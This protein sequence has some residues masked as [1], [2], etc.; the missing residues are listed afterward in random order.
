MEKVIVKDRNNQ[1]GFILNNLI[2]NATFTRTYQKNSQLQLDWTMFN[3]G[4]PAAELVTNENLVQFR[5]QNYTITLP[6]A[7]RLPSNTT[8]QVTAIHVGY[9]CD[10]FRVANSELPAGNYTPQQIM[11]HFF[12]GNDQGYSYKIVGSFDAVNIDSVGKGTGRTGLDLVAQAWPTCVLYPDNKQ[13]IIY[14]SDSWFHKVNNQFTFGKNLTEVDSQPDSSSSIVNI[15]E[16]YGSPIQNNNSSSDSN[17]NA[18]KYAVHAAYRDEQSIANWGP[19]PQADDLTVDS[20]VD[21]NELLAMAAKSAHPNPQ[22]QVTFNYD[23]EADIRESEIWHIN[24]PKNGYQSDAKIT[25]LV[26]YPLDHSQ[27]TQITVDDSQMNML[28]FDLSMQ[29]TTQEAFIKANEAAKHAAQ[30]SSSG[31]GWQT[32]DGGVSDVQ[33]QPNS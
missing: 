26:E 18:D 20:N 7:T 4:S 13:W 12:D 10:S 1:T 27:V 31:S 17:S 14:E 11:A 23:G 24:D 6:S 28:D 30:S 19:H 33:Y 2:D 21:Q 16:C 5:G 25:G 32:I 15:I 9:R 29:K 8:T 22:M 3:D